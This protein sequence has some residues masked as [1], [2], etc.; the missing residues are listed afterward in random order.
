MGVVGGPLE[1]GAEGLTAVG[2]GGDGKGVN[3]VGPI[4]EP[5]DPN[6]DP[7]TEEGDRGE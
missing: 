5:L 7:Y 6:H 4:G 3:Q 1:P 2:A